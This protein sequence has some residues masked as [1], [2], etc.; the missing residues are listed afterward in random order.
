MPKTNAAKA[1]QKNKKKKKPETVERPKILKIGIVQGGRIIEEKLIRDRRDVSIGQAARNTFIIPSAYM[2]A[3]FNLLKVTGNTYTLKFTEGMDGRIG[4]SG[5]VRTLSQIKQMGAAKKA[6]EFWTIKLETSARGK[7]TVGDVTV[8]F[9]FVKAPEIRPKSR[10]P[11]FIR[12]GVF[13]EW[14][15]TF[16]SIISGTAAA[17]LVLA[18]LFLMVDKPEHIGGGK[19]EQ[20]ARVEVK[21]KVQE[22]K[23]RSADEGDRGGS[24]DQAG[25]DAME[26]EEDKPRKSTRASR[27]SSDAGEE[28]DK[29]DPDKPKRLDSETE[30][31]L[32]AA[33]TGAI[34]SDDEK[35]AFKTASVLTPTEGDGGGPVAYGGGDQLAKG[36]QNTGLDSS[37]EKFGSAGGG[38]GGGPGASSRGGGNRMRGTRGGVGRDIRGPSRD[39][40]DSRPRVSRPMGPRPRTSSRIPSLGG[41]V[42]KSLAGKIKSVLR[43]RAGG[44]KRIYEQHI[45]T[46]KF[47]C[48]LNISFI[49]NKNGRLS[50][51]NVAGGCPGSFTSAVKRNVS[52]WRLPPGASGFQKFT[53]SF[54]H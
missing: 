40:T 54:S 8:L 49:L 4:I 7:L 1:A 36:V 6:G 9:Q 11:S 25:M 18:I 16:G 12:G 20:M 38:G 27:A 47:S 48:S 15:W 37:A 19:F 50:N 53:V 52:S 22:A 34:S 39:V 26:A 31:A 24:G 35:S 46:N 29:G 51:V 13:G 32:A 43:R 14:D 5:K 21:R 42:P 44:L 10:L 33:L 28:E 17:H 23:D 30:D 3:Q 41:G 45:Q 2:P